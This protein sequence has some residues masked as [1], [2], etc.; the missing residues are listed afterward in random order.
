MPQTHAFCAEI[1]TATVHYIAGA[2]NQPFQRINKTWVDA[3]AKFVL[4]FVIR[5]KDAW[6]KYVARESCIWINCGCLNT[7]IKE[8][9]CLSLHLLCK[10]KLNFLRIIDG[11]T[12][13]DMIRLNIWV[14][15][16]GNSVGYA[17][18]RQLKGDHVPICRGANSYE[19]KFE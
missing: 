5:G 8:K 11:W 7:K 17:V 9:K 2:T 15:V 19:V 13:I 6:V 4:L 10:N 3:R 1:S 12:A 16:C 14:L 18:E